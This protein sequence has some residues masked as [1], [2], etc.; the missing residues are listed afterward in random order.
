[1]LL[2]LPLALPLSLLPLPLLAQL[3]APQYLLL[4]AWNRR[5]LRENTY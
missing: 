2:L 4:L 3:A 1:L 5:H